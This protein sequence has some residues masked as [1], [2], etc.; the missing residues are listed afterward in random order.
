MHRPQ[1]LNICA[2][3]I[4]PEPSH[5]SAHL[6]NHC[7]QQ[8]SQEPIGRTNLLACCMLEGCLQTLNIQLISRKADCFVSVFFRMGECHCSK[9]TD[10]CRGDP[11]EGLLA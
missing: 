8:T 7:R 10:V 4:S 9:H 2:I 5:H 3:S 6:P 11:L 1:L